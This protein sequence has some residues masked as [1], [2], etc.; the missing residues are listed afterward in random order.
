MRQ[1]DHTEV[2]YKILNNTSLRQ[3]ANW[4]RSLLLYTGKDINQLLNFYAAPLFKAA[5]DLEDGL[6]ELTLRDGS[7][8][9]VKFFYMADG[10]GRRS[11]L[12]VG[13]ATSKYP[14]VWNHLLNTQYK[15]LSTFSPI[16]R[17]VVSM[18]QNEPKDDSMSHKKR[19]QHAASN[20]GQYGPNVPGRDAANY[21]PDG[22]HQGLLCSPRVLSYMIRAVMGDDNSDSDEFATHLR[23]LGL[24][25]RIQHTEHDGR[26]VLKMYGNDCRALHGKGF[27]IL[28]TEDFEFMS[29]SSQRESMTNVWEAMEVVL[30]DLNNANLDT[31]MPP[32]AF[33][34]S[35]HLFLWKGV[36]V[37]GLKF[38]TPTLREMRDQNPY[39]K[40]SLTLIGLT[41]AHL[42]VDSFE[43]WHRV[44]KYRLQRDLRAGGKA[45]RPGVLERLLVC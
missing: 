43:A 33:F 8:L 18:E 32:G 17:T 39:F 16:T 31:A 3:V 14:M 28:H 20:K 6:V 22:F 5:H 25:F 35:M 7:K 23:K 21:F 9:S 40:Q 44:Q 26:L 34:K 15:N 36:V 30:K 10:A 41:L 19:T 27:Q 42:S 38:I 11:L 2:T 45:G 12:G 13:T 4:H 37:Y 24:K 1:Q 29:S